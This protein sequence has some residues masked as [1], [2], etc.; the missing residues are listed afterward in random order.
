MKAHHQGVTIA[1]ADELKGY[2]GSA[3][4][5]PEVIQEGMDLQLKLQQDSIDKGL[6]VLRAVAPAARNHGGQRATATKIMP[7]EIAPST[8][9]NSMQV[10][11]NP[12]DKGTRLG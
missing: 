6:G 4:A 12:S 10:G 3:T 8:P 2:L 11:Q 5:T 1:S 7:P 9:N